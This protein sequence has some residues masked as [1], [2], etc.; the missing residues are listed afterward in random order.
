M[1]GLAFGGCIRSLPVPV[2]ALP[3]TAVKRPGR[4]SYDL[5]AVGK[6]LSKVAVAAFP[7]GSP[8]RGVKGAK[9]ER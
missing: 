7:F 5:A 8:L 4:V 1:S 3:P 9:M 2:V 6:G